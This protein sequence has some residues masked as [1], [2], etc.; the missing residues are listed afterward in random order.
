VT[1]RPAIILHS[2]HLKSTIYH[3]L[4]R[5]K[6]DFFE[7]IPLSGANEPSIEH[8]VTLFALIKQIQ[9][10]RNLP[11]AKLITADAVKQ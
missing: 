11:P 3:S 9:E 1:L 7:K 2:K 10:T 6:R 8:L 4:Y 5:K